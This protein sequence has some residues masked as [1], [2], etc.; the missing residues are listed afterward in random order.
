VIL[1]ILRP[2]LTVSVCD[3]T[4]KKARAGEEIVAE[5]GL[6]IAV[7]PSRVQ[8]VLEMKTFDTLVGRAIASLK[9]ALGW[10]APHWDAFD[11]LLL[12][13]GPAWV[14]ERGEARHAG[15]LHGLELRK[16]A[17]YQTPRTGAESVILKVW[18]ADGDLS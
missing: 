10:L 4:V 18:R 6:E 3:S 1:A 14:E 5:L 16:A 15:L 13:K 8:E 17:A 9:K 12:I 2:D 7:Y 11:Q